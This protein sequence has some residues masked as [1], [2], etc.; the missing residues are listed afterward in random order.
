[1]TALGSVAEIFSS[2]TRPSEAVSTSYP[3]MASSTRNPSSV[4]GSSSAT[5]IRWAMCLGHDGG[6]GAGSLSGGPPEPRRRDS[7]PVLKGTTSAGAFDFPEDH[8]DGGLPE[9]RPRDRAAEL[10]HHRAAS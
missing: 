4:E 9:R 2:A 7:N 3:Q 6:I 10:D 1:M 8:I 5:K